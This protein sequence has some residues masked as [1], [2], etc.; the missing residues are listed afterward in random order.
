MCSKVGIL[1]VAQI[2]CEVVELCKLQWSSQDVLDAETWK[3]WQKP[4]ITSGTS[5]KRSGVDCKQA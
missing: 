2:V 3:F 4:Q 5:Q 1:W